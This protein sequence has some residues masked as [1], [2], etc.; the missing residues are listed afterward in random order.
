LLP[1]FIDSPLD[2]L[3]FGAFGVFRLAEQIFVGEQHLL[4]QKSSGPQRPFEVRFFG[5][6]K[7]AYAIAVF[8]LAEV[9][10]VTVL[11]FAFVSQNAETIRT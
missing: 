11:S 5:A 1:H 4:Q 7:T 8:D 3:S 10:K 9:Q 6:K 2:A